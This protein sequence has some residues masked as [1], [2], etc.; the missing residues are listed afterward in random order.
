MV[1]VQRAVHACAYRSDFLS[2]SFIFCVIPH[3]L[4]CLQK[5]AESTLSNYASLMFITLNLWLS[6]V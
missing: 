4:E 3:L 6:F 2:E 1:W 5:D